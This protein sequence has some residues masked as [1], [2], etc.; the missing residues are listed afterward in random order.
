MWDEILNLVC[1]RYNTAI[2]EGIR[3]TPFELTFGRKAHLPSTIAAITATS[4]EEVFRLWKRR[5]ELYL[6]LARAK[7]I[8]E[9]GK[10]TNKRNQGR[11]IRLQNVFEVNDKVLMHS[12]HKA[13]KL[14][15]V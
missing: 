14:D 13:S 2:H 11:K 6:Q 9:K 4:K 5:Q 10:A 3:C 15:S 8:I 7:V 12:D 1:F